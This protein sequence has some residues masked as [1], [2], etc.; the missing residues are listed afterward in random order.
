MEAL[1]ATYNGIVEREQEQGKSLHPAFVSLRAYT[2]TYTEKTR[3]NYA[4]LLQKVRML[5]LALSST[6]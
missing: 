1:N 3:Q 5:L 2:R 6:F 4:E